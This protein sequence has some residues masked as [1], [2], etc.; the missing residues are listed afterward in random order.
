MDRVKGTFVAKPPE[1]PDLEDILGP[2][3]S[4][5]ATIKALVAKERLGPGRVKGDK[6]S[7]ER[8]RR[9]LKSLAAMPVVGDA[10]NMA[11]IHRHTLGQWIVKSRIG[12]P[13]DVYDINLIEDD[14]ETKVRFHE[15]YDYAMDDG[16]DNLE[17]AM[18]Q[19]A[20]GYLEPLTFQG[21]VIYKIDPRLVGL[22]LPDV[23]TYLLDENGK[24]VPETLFKQDPDLMMFIM[25]C[26][27]KSVYGNK[28][29][30]DVNHRGGVLVVAQKAISG[31]SLNDEEADFRKQA[32]DV[33]F[34]EV[35]E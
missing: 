9:V 12:V 20:L 21:R 16:I 3:P 35:E 14:P 4:D 10:C 6:F 8:M 15:A 28:T 5:T 26:R 34:E 25:K 17:R 1:D 24:P 18:M 23:E 29:E 22:G 27:R 2:K 11:G 19:R 31:K 30:V 32:V 7:Q 13:G 33:E